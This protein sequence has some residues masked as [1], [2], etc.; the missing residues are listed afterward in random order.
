MF[1]VFEGLD[2]SGKSSLMKS[3]ENHLVQSGI[4]CLMT[5][6]PGGTVLGDQLRQ[7]ILQKSAEPPVPRAELLMYEASRAQHVECL[8]RP[9]LL[10]KKWVLCDRFSASSIAFQSGGRSI[11]ESQVKW[12]NSFATANLEAELTVL[13]DLPVEESENRRNRRALATGEDQDRIEMEKQDFHERVRQSFLAQAKAEPTKWLVLDAS[14]T[15]AELSAELIQFLKD[16]KWL[17]C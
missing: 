14:H 9:A 10:A 6:E 5:R 8:I 12:L 17:V 16:K 2:G 7:L 3:L 15:P 1:L 11:E 4:Q 13:L